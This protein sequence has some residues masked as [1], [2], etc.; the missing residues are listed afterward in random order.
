VAKFFADECVEALVVE[1]LRALG[2]DV[3]KASEVCA[4][5]PDDLVL[6]YSAAQ[7]RV[8]ITDDQG[9]GELAVRLAQAAVGV[10][11]LSLYALPAGTRERH[12]AN[13]I[14]R[15]ADRVEGHLT[16]IEPGRVRVRPLPKRSGLS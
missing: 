16:I 1:E 3:E 6:K 8:L 5:Q 14:S 7:G 13:Q 15:L 10:V 4:G 2:H 9:F 11:I 12:A